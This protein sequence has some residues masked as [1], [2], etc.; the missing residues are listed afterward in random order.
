MSDAVLT[1]NCLE[2]WKSLIF[3]P[4]GRII[5][6]CGAPLPEGDFGS[7]DGLG[8]GE[9]GG[10]ETVF[11]N[12]AFRH[13]R[14]ELLTG[15]LQKTCRECRS[16]VAGDIPVDDLR[17]KVLAHLRYAGKA[18]DDTADLTEKFAFTDC[19]TNVTDKCN[20]ACIYCYEH[21]NDRP[22]DGM[23]NYR[24]MDRMRFLEVVSFLVGQGLE[25]LNFCGVG[26]LTVHPQWRELC[27]ELWQRYPSLRLSLVS[28]FGRP[29]SAADLEVLGRFFQIRISCDTLDPEKYAWLRRGGRLP[30]V[31][32]NVENLVAG[33]KPGSSHPK[34]IF[35]VTESD[36][37]LS[38]LTDLARFA[39][40]RNISLYMSNLAVVPDSVAAR[41]GSLHRITDLPDSRIPEVWE[42]LHDLPRRTRAEN[43]P[44]DFFCDLGPLYGMFRE[45]AESMT[46]NRFVPS[47]GEIVYQA[48]SAAHTKNPDMYLR[49]FFLSFDDCIKGIHIAA[50]RT[51]DI[52]LPYAAGLLKYRPVFCR[53]VEG[54]SLRLFIGEPSTVLVG[55]FLSFSAAKCPGRFTNVLFEV[56][57]YEAC[58]EGETT[59][60]SV[61][62]AARIPFLSRLVTIRE[63][64]DSRFEL[65]QTV[66]GILKAYPWGHRLAEK[67]FRAG[68]RLLALARG[69]KG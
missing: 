68:L 65:A 36:A 40:R 35:I 9:G 58:E 7:I 4:D 42:I 22:G 37:I 14:R 50:G 52:R 43:P 24:D 53:E 11:A 41:T 33:F 55:N 29:F 69:L 10:C 49:K 48:F 63:F 67:V 66:S 39:V 38:G 60:G 2:P 21:S 16:V 32:E 62:C 57:S 47:E 5:P 64:P 17:G 6:C 20:F 31:L 23:R 44:I 15:D 28:N 54:R 1:K 30:V 46:C 19:F 18:V 25:Y 27:Q 51:A 3:S 26:E 12:D 8:A 45:R 56:L 13:L 34:L 61:D 59:A